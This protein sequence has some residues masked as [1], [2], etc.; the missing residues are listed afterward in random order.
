MVSGVLGFD[1]VVLGTTGVLF[2]SLGIYVLS[3]N[4]RQKSSVYFAI[5]AFSLA[6]ITLLEVLIEN[7]S[8]ADVI[9]LAIRLHALASMMCFGTMLA[10]SL[11]LDT[12]MDATRRMNGRRAI[13]VGVSTAGVIIALMMDGRPQSWSGF[14]TTGGLSVMVLISSISLLAG[15]SIKSYFQARASSTDE[16]FRSQCVILSGGLI[17]TLAGVESLYMGLGLG[18]L[19][20]FSAICFLATEGVLIHLVVVHKLFQLP[21]MD[22]RG[23]QADGDIIDPALTGSTLL[24]ESKDTRPAYEMFIQELS[25]GKEGMIVTRT[26]PDQVRETYEIGSSRTLWLCSQP[27]ADRVDPLGLSI[28]QNIL[29]EH[30][31]DKKNGVILLEGVE[32][33]VSENSIDKVLRLIYTLR[34]AA[35]ISGAKL[36]MPLDT[37]TLSIKD[38]ALIERE[39]TVMSGFSVSD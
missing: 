9:N 33:L 23:M 13:L 36:I 3:K 34:D 19:I 22:G 37:S 6:A 25:K 28:L 1:S 7:T 5:T 10:L 27:G 38:Q 14:G 30:M 4:H 35:V 39:F 11:E 31:R 2:L 24:I 12:S 8:Q 29:L 20:T 21:D 18:G 17:I 16:T 15:A 32:Y 26:H